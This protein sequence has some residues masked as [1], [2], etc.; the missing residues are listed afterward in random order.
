MC[1]PITMVFSL[2][3]VI[4]QQQTLKGSAGELPTPLPLQGYFPWNFSETPFIMYIS[5]LCYRKKLSW[6]K[7][8]L[9]SKLLQHNQTNHKIFGYKPKERGDIVFFWKTPQK[10]ID[11]HDKDCDDVGEGWLVTSDV[12]HL[13]GG[14]RGQ[15]HGEPEMQGGG[16]DHYPHK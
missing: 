2:L 1:V 7:K 5:V 12:K 16:G 9:S 8:G 15:G 10:T 4:K 13:S 3:F 11:C 6:R 14:Q